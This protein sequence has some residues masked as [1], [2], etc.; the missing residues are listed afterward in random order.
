MASTIAGDGMMHDTIRIVRLLF[1]IHPM[2]S[3]QQGCHPGPL[4]AGNFLPYYEYSIVLGETTQA[5]E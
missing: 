5:R 4:L 3:S 2:T 1:V